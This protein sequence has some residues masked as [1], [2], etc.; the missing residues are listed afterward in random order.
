MNRYALL[1]KIAEETGCRVLEKEPM[2]KHTTFQIG[3]EADLY[4]AVKS[5][6]ALK[7]ILKT[8]KEQ[9]IPIFLLGKGSNL[10]VSDQGIRGA[11]I[12]LEGEF[13]EVHLLE[14]NKIQ[15]GAGATLAKL[16]TFAL[17]NSLSGLEFAWG[18]PGSVGGAAFMNAGA[19]SGEMKDVLVCCEHITRDGI[20][21]AFKAEELELSYRRSIYGD[22]DY[23]IT[24]IVVEL[25][26]EKED[27]IRLRMDDFMD[28][29]KSKQPLK[30]PSAGSIFKRPKGHF[31][32]GLI[33]QYG[34]KGASVGGAMV[35]KKHSGFIVNTGNATCKD[36]LSL[37]DRIKGRIREETGIEMECEVKIVGEF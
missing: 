19:Y 37:I 5:K 32:G 29:R 25:K 1:K 3:G 16:C 6:D 28:R 10:L 18:I 22:C 15:C 9:S 8:A 14:G 7:K 24:S 27:L 34:L 35:S 31:A 20:S 21:G 13:S 36:V 23:I 33:E 11:V 2:A 30:Y 4:L 26:K 17:N 12:K